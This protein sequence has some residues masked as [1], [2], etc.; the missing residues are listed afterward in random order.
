MLYKPVALLP[1]G[2]RGREV[3]IMLQVYG[4][5][6]AGGGLGAGA[7]GVPWWV[8]AFLRNVTITV[9]SQELF[10]RLL[11]LELQLTWVASCSGEQM[12]SHHAPCLPC[13]L[14]GC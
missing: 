6:V 12:K 7:R 5:L 10:V 4:C 13:F 3:E 8:T 1:R 2:H 11:V 14:S 9:W